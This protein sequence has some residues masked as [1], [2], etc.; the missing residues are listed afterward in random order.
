M[1]SK[2]LTAFINGTLD[3]TITLPCSVQSGTKPTW[4]KSNEK[5]TF[6]NSKVCNYVYICR[7]HASLATH[8]AGGMYVYA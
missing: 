2:G 7:M 8:I 4:F 6:S 5:I 3:S 1:E